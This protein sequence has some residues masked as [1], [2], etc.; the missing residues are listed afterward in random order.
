MDYDGKFLKIRKAIHGAGF[1]NFYQA[2]SVSRFHK[3]NIVCE[4][5]A[6]ASRF[7]IC[8]DGGYGA[9]NEFSI[10]RRRFPENGPD[11][12]TSYISESEMAAAIE[13]IGNEIRM[14]K[15]KGRI[16]THD[17]AARIVELFEDVLC[18]HGVKVPS[19]E[20]DER[21][22][23][24]D[25]ALYGSTYSDLMDE[26]ESALVDLLDQHKPGAEIIRG[27]FSGTM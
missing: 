1:D 24:N 2:G 25:A 4:S 23:G 17:E 11:E 16:Y 27:E 13:E 10:V 19:P 9:K 12:R 3:M 26:V 20:D 8:I 6:L 21:E 14:E 22:P 7:W 18:E 5:W 15:M